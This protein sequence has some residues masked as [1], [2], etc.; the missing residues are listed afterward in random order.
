MPGSGREGAHDGGMALARRQ[1]RPGPEWSLP[2]WRPRLL[3]LALVVSGVAALTAA[4]DVNVVV[5]GG[6]EV[7]AGAALV[8]AGTSM[9]H[10]A[11]PA[12]WRSP[13]GTVSYVSHNHWQPA[14]GEYSVELHGTFEQIISVF[15]GGE[16]NLSFAMA[17]NPLGGAAVKSLTVT[18]LPPEGG[19]AGLAS[20]S[21]DFDA[22]DSSP[23][24]M[25]WAHRWLV[26]AAPPSKCRLLLRF[27]STTHGD[28][29]PALDAISGIGPLPPD[30]R[31]KLCRGQAETPTSCPP[32]PPPPPPP[33]PAVLPPVP[34][35][36][37]AAEPSAGPSPVLRTPSPPSSPLLPPSPA[38][39]PTPSPL[40]PPMSAP[41]APPCLPPAPLATPPPPPP[42][43]PLLEVPGPAPMHVMAPAPAP[44]PPAPAHASPPAPMPSLMGAPPPTPAGPAPAPAKAPHPSPPSLASPSPAPIAF[45]PLL[46]APAPSSWFPPAFPPGPPSPLHPPPAPP[47][48]SPQSPPAPPAPSLAPPTPSP[49][50]SSLPPPLQSPPPPASPLLQQP[51][52]PLVSPS[53]STP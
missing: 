22:R 8:A 29:G 25:G 41:V 38:Q 50:P 36:A 42:P 5:N 23:S 44:P 34:L 53:P 33:A 2:P 39:A 17:G 40:P 4:L 27:A 32:Q 26:F 19:G 37:L 48:L 9:L 24:A 1:R 46:P 31:S 3:L 14:D 6:L 7:A 49:S 15:P 10:G 30:D 11:L 21:F 28:F 47:P 12:R 45:P 52:P 13:N 18:V 35:P 43:S 16:Y 20:G 51:P